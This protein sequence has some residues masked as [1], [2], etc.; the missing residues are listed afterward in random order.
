MTPFLIA[1]AFIALGFLLQAIAAIWGLSKRH[2]S[3]YRAIYTVLLI[4]DRN[5]LVP[6][7]GNLTRMMETIRAEDIIDGFYELGEP[8]LFTPFARHDTRVHFADQVNQLRL[9]GSLINPGEPIA[10][11]LIAAGA[12]PDLSVSPGSAPLAVLRAISLANL[13]KKSLVIERIFP[14]PNQQGLP[15]EFATTLFN[16]MLAKSI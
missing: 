13:D 4:R 5:E 6:S 3:R 16:Q 15:I 7:D 1:I 10:R 8:R 2:E 14:S 12:L 11:L 9:E